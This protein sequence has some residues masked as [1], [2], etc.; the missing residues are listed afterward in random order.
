MYWPPVIFSTAGGAEGRI[1]QCCSI[2]SVNGRIAYVH[3]KVDYNLIEIL[4]LIAYANK[5]PLNHPADVSYLVRGGGGGW[6]G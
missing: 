5:S 2:A 6:G 3:I 4:L 1:Q